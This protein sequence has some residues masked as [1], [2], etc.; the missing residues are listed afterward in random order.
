[1]PSQA[2]AGSIQARMPLMKYR[3]ITK[4]AQACTR[5]EP[6][7]IPGATSNSGNSSMPLITQV[8]APCRSAKSWFQT[9]SN[10]A[11]AASSARLMPCISRMRGCSHSSGGS[12]LSFLRVT[13]RLQL[14]DQLCQ[15]DSQRGTQLLFMSVQRTLAVDTGQVAWAVRRTATP[16]F[17]QGGFAIGQ[18]TDQHAVVQQRHHHAQQGGFLSAV[19]G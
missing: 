17:G 10:T 4:Q 1:M 6:S 19:H 15:T 5:A 11:R 7:S 16:G 14:C 2:R 8:R 3:F 13:G 18:A 12:G 9:T